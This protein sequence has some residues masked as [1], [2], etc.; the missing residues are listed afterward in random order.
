MITF[1]LNDPTQSNDDVILTEVKDLIQSSILSAKKEKLKDITDRIDALKVVSSSMKINNIVSDSIQILQ[2][3]TEDF[4]DNVEASIKKMISETMAST[5][6]T[7]N[8]T[9]DVLHHIIEDQ[10]AKHYE[11]HNE[12]FALHK[13][14]D[15]I[16]AASYRSRL[17]L[18]NALLPIYRSLIDSILQGSQEAFDK[19]MT[20]LPAV[21]RLPIMLKTLSE[22]SLK[23]FLQNI[24]SI[25]SGTINY[26]FCCY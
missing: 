6:A 11:K 25:R 4:N 8:T 22:N 13:N 3:L 23:S 15:A 1:H 24:I 10:I 2:T 21:K 14:S 7:V 18:S 19:R 5:G 16:K 26:Y 12:I 20:R 17:E 9:I